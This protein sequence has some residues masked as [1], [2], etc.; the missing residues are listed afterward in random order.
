M[1]PPRLAR[2]RYLI[3]AAGFRAWGRRARVSEPADA[4]DSGLNSGGPGVRSL[5]NL[6][7]PGDRWLDSRQD[8]FRESI[9]RRHSLLVTEPVSVDGACDLRVLVV[10]RRIGSPASFGK[11]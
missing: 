6:S 2:L 9:K 7:S 3:V 1:V 4:Q 8:R 5:Q 10:C 11:T